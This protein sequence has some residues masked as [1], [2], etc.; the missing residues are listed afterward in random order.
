MLCGEEQQPSFQVCCIISTIALLHFCMV[1]LFFLGGKEFFPCPK[2]VFL[3]VTRSCDLCLWWPKPVGGM[4]TFF[5]MCSRTLPALSAAL[6]SAVCL[7]PCPLLPSWIGCVPQVGHPW[8][9][10]FLVVPEVEELQS[11]A[12]GDWAGREKRHYL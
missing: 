1:S 11:G 2:P 12:T 4:D 7:L 9:K 6:L 10:P 8:L 5:G 3:V